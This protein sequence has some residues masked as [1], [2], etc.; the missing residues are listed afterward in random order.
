MYMLKLKK[1]HEILKKIKKYCVLYDNLITILNNNMNRIEKNTIWK[2]LLE[3]GWQTECVGWKYSS[4]IIVLLLLLQIEYMQNADIL[5]LLWGDESQYRIYILSFIS[6]ALLMFFSDILFGRRFFTLF[7][8]PLNRYTTYI[9]CIEKVKTNWLNVWIK[10]GINEWTTQKQNYFYQNGTL[11]YS[12]LAIYNS[13][14]NDMEFPCF[15]YIITLNTYF[16]EN[17]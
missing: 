5:S 11:E 1:R 2:H 12:S 4:N 13:I 6:D 8:I 7:E 15:Y 14:E 10:Y 16:H 17:W 3:K 9:R